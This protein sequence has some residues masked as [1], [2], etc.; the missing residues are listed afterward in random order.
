MKATTRSKLE[1][2]QETLDVV[3]D[4]ALEATQD[5]KQGVKKL[6]ALKSSDSAYEGRYGE[7]AAI[8]FLLKLKADAAHQTLDQIIEAEPD[9]D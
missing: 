5:F 7:L 3:L 1:E 6:R 8:A 9:D 2:L 4:E